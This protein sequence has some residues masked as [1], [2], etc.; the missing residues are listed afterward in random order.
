MRLISCFSHVR[1]GLI[2][3]TQTLKALSIFLITVSFY[4]H[5]ADAYQ[6][7]VE[8]FESKGGKISNVENNFDCIEH[9]K[10]QTFSKKIISLLALADDGYRFAGWEGGCNSSLGPL[11]TLKLNGNEKVSAK[12][13]KSEHIPPPVQALLLLHD[14]D[15]KH[16]VWNEFVKQRFNNRC[17]VVYGG[18]VLDKDSFDISN[19]TACYRIAFGYYGLIRDSLENKDA[20]DTNRAY[21]SKVHL[22]FEIRAAVLG[23]L[24]RHPN[25]NV[26]LIGNGYAAIPALSYLQTTTE[27]RKNI[28]GL[29]SLSSEDRIADKNTLS[30]MSADGELKEFPLVKIAA[31]PAQ[32]R[33]INAAL[34]TFVIAKWP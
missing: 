18:V 32:S 14:I 2:T 13:V 22:G 10:I 16:T 19:H 12:F 23:L 28:N 9:C 8:V 21:Y 3:H 4:S 34:D 31:H 25:L 26:T 27:E 33:K 20:V 7:D 24:N 5:Q 30:A 17:P 11:C 1:Q 29:L 6:L 15:E